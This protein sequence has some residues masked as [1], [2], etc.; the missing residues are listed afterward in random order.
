MTSDEI[1]YREAL[2]RDIESLRREIAPLVHAEELEF[3]KQF[4]HEIGRLRADVA[5]LREELSLRDGRG[6]PLAPPP[7][8]E[9]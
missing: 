6:A 3:R 1:H 2:Q 7:A 4:Q 8:D 5:A 9:R